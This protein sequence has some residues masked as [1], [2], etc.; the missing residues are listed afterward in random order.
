MV[1]GVTHQFPDDA[2]DAEIQA[3]LSGP[4][5]PHT[6]GGRVL[7]AF[8]SAGNFIGNTASGIAN[9]LNPSE[10]NT[11]YKMWQ[12]GNGAI[13]IPVRAGMEAVTGKK[14]TP[15]NEEQMARSV[16]GS[17]KDR[18]GGMQQI[19]DTIYKD[20]VG[21]LSDL[22]MLTGLGE[23]ALPGRVGK[24]AGTVSKWT[25]PTIAVKPV[26]LLMRKGAEQ[27]AE[28]SMGIRA[29][30]RL[31]GKTPGAGILD[32]T[33]WSMGPT[34]V[35]KK[36]VEKTSQLTKQLEKLY[37]DATSKGVKQSIEPARNVVDS[38]VKYAKQGTNRPL[39]SELESQAKTL[40]EVPDATYF[41]ETE[42]PVGSHTSIALS[43]P[44]DTPYN[45][46]Y[47]PSPWF[48]TGKLPEPEIAAMQSP[49]D[50]LRHKREFGAEHVEFKPGQTSGANQTAKKV[51]SELDKAGDL[52]VPAGEELN[53]RISSLIPVKIRGQMKAAGPG[54]LG[55]AAGQM[56]A[57]TGALASAAS[58]GNGSVPVGMFIKT[59]L[60]ASGTAIAKAMNAP[61]KLMGMKLGSGT[62]GQRMAQA[63]LISQLRRGLLD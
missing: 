57:Q 50:I 25:N 61:G 14:I 33:G 40:R 60:P 51:Y 19:G 15:L 35:Y 7:N 9:I 44:Y 28:K 30:D 21:V 4:P 20:P 54:L 3:A 13:Q 22:S 56:M 8:S 59:V 16:L 2:T 46:P 63:A 23:A 45:T 41:G 39:V 26:G 5:E 6:P 17:Y 12:L 18:Y 49:S 58:L 52:A 1:D 27:L 37:S 29:E 31:L 36:A 32:E 34:G 48:P 43:S 24:I 38:A 62:V 55:E 10:D 53:Q 42:F 11:I 47:G